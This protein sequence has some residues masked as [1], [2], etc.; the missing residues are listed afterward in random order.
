MSKLVTWELVATSA[1]RPRALTWL[2]W[3][4]GEP[5][6]GAQV[7]LQAH[8]LCI[9]R[10]HIIQKGLSRGACSAKVKEAPAGASQPKYTGLGDIYV[11]ASLSS[12]PLGKGGTVSTLK[13]T[14]V[15]K[16]RQGRKAVF[17]VQGI[18]FFL[19]SFSF[20][21]DCCSPAYKQ[22]HRYSLMNLSCRCVMVTADSQQPL[23]FCCSD[24][25][26]SQKK[27][28]LPE[29]GLHPSELRVCLEPG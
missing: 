28:L 21:S 19:D 25:A 7:G 24:A 16:Q 13:N 9:F 22:W 1:D 6:K 26:A 11:S 10:K 20:R 18:F 8:D 27:S 12:P 29:L 14:G 15:E 17:L 23:N 3:V 4:C 2:S 5:Q